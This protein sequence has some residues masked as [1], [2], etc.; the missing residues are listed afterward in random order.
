MPALKHLRPAC[1]QAGLPLARRTVLAHGQRVAHGL[2]VRWLLVL[3]AMLV[4]C[5]S[6]Q[7]ADAVSPPQKV[8]LQ[9]KWTHAFQFAGYYAALHQGYYRDAGLDVELRQGGPDVDVVS[10]LVQGRAQFGVGTSSLLLDRHAGK[11]VVVLGVVFQHSPLVLIA[12]QRSPTQTVHS[13]AHG[14]IMLEPHSEELLAYLQ[15]EG[16]LAES[17]TPMPH[18]D[19]LKALRSGRVDAI[20]GYSTYEPYFLQRDAVPHHIYSPRAAGIDFYGD[21]LFTTQSLADRQPRVAEA[22]RDASLR[23]WQYAMAHPQVVMDWVAQHAPGIDRGLMAHEAKVMTELIRADL[24]EPGYMH[25]GR[26]LHIAEV[27]QRQGMLGGGVDS[28]LSGFIYHPAAVVAAAAP[29]AAPVWT[30]SQLMT[31]SAVLVLSGVVLGVAEYIR[32]VNTQ[33]RTAMQ[34]LRRSEE[35]HRLLAD[36]AS[37]V[38]WT[39]DAQGRFTY[40]SPSVQRLRGYTV[41]EVLAQSMDEALTPESAAIAHQVFGRS[42][43]CLQKGLPVPDFRGEL[44]QPCKDGSTVWT[45][46]TVSG[47][48]NAEGS[49]VGFLG[50]TRDITERRRAQEKMAR[51]AQY[52]QLTQLPNR[53]LL[54]DRLE[55]A[56]ARHQRL[57]NR[58]SA[59]P[60]TDAPRLA[61]MFVDLDRFKPVNDDH[62]HAVGDALLQQVAQRMTACVRASDTVAR[63][64][65]DEFIVLLPEVYSTQAALTVAENIR[66]G[67]RQ[68]FE[69][70]ADGGATLTLHISSSVGVALFP[71]HASGMGDLMRVADEAMY[72]AKQAGRDCIRLAVPVPATP[73]A[74]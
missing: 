42:F 60:Q 59:R 31:L 28:L 1:P 63:I 26:W 9:L 12:R 32:R 49:F 52:D 30:R 29:V 20:S 5:A 50:V 38:I 8:V 16:R 48:V 36:N 39:M 46:L 74:S 17:I 43:R 13:L 40:V 11:P 64:G 45:E 3:L 4:V 70:V 73:V 27:Y 65:G 2:W 68:A 58:S 21:N 57:L 24:V 62:G 22:F 55:Q 72:L 44:E 69:I 61:L 51:M 37:D 56:I 14:R 47:M 41:Q 6:G 15:A 25:P 18:V 7:A 66:N 23:G 53:A 71:D 10:E 33:L 34:Q 54:L 67:L 19:S 35:R